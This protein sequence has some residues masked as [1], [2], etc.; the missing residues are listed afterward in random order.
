MLQEQ[1]FSP[2]KHSRLSTS[3]HLSQNIYIL[4]P[5][6]PQVSRS[7]YLAIFMLASITRIWHNFCYRL[8]R[9]CW[10][11]LSAILV[12]DAREVPKGHSN[13]DSFSSINVQQVIRCQL[14][15]LEVLGQVEN[16]IPMANF[17]NW[18]RWLFQ[19]QKD[20]KKLLTYSLKKLQE[21]P[22]YLKQSLC[23]PRG[24]FLCLSFHSLEDRCPPT[25][26]THE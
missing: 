13:S 10:E 15:S 16:F 18:Q 3:Q 22:S 7:I 11:Q 21:L 12:V 6:K 17:S 25:T 1:V 9:Q 19:L 5:T 20:F 23:W 4:T 2:D 24:C 8:E 26:D 14:N